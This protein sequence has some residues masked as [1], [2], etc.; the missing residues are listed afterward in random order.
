S[1]WEYAILNSAYIKNL[2]P[3]SATEDKTPF[4]LFYGYPLD[5]SHLWLFGCLAYAHIPNDICHKYDC[6]S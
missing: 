5:V 6:I 4:E 1:F 2:L 3:L